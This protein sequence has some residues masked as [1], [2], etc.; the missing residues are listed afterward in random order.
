VF[1][2]KAGYRGLAAEGAIR[3]VGKRR[4]CYEIQGNLDWDGSNLNVENIKN[5]E[6]GKVVEKATA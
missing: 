4:P 6:L 2:G 5:L 1:F 3:R